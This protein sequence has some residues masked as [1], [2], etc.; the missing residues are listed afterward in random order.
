L[1]TKKIAA[2]VVFAALTIALNL[3]PAKVPAPYAAFLIYQIWEIPIVA[4]FL[5]FGYKVGIAISIINT[6]VLLVAFPGAIITGPLYNLAAVTSMLFGIFIAHR[7]LK[8]LINKRRDV[9]TP[10]ILTLFG[11]VFRVGFMSLINYTFLPFPPPIGF[12][13]P[14]EAVVASLPVIGFFNATLALYT[15]PIGYLLD[16]IIRLRMKGA[17]ESFQQ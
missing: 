3:S 10:T 15:I 2:I 16:R 7:F 8:S 17:I 6:I 14:T 9:L 4:A 5:L 13:M 1:D 12:G 11:T